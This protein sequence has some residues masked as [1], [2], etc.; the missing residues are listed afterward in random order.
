MI[1]CIECP[2]GGHH[3][4]G[5]PLG[6][7]LERDQGIGEQH[8]RDHHHVHQHDRHGCAIDVDLAR[9]YEYQ[10]RDGEAEHHRRCT[11]SQKNDELGKERNSL[12]SADDVDD[13]NDGCSDEEQRE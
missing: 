7:A 12:H 2:V 6:G 11:R 4:V 8:L 3:G 1:E 10:S 9:V 13:T 5:D